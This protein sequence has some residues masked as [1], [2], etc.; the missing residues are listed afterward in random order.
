MEGI[1]VCY[2]C[3]HINPPG[4]TRCS[5]CGASL[6]GEENVFPAVGPEEEAE[7]LFGEFSADDF[8]RQD[9]ENAEEAEEHQARFERMLGEACVRLEKVAERRAVQQLEQMEEKL[10]ELERELDGFIGRKLPA[11]GRRD[12]TEE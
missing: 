5:R 10:D 7:E 12:E 1:R 3:G 2:Q 6:N 11:S 8:S 4:E 9:A